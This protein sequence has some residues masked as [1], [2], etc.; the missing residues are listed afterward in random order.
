V[1][2]FHRHGGEKRKVRFYVYRLALAEERLHE[3]VPKLTVELLA[4]SLPF[5]HGSLSKQ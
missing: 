5:I 3:L 1:E 4:V 2:P